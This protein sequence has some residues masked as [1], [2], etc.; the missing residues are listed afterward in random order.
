MKRFYKTAEVV[1]AEGGWTVVLDGRPVRTPARA[2]L[3]LPG[4]TLAERIA[5]EWNAQGERIDPAAMHHTG[6]ANAAIDRVGRDREDFVRNAVAFADTDTLLY[7]AEPGDPLAPRQEQLWEP[8]VRWAET[9]YDIVMARTAGI[10]PAAQPGEALDRL[11]AAVRARNDFELAGLLSMAGLLQSLLAALAAAEGAFDADTVWR[12]CQ[13]E[14]DYQAEQWG[15][16][17]E[18]AA[19]MKEKR[20]EF[21]AALGFC[22]VAKAP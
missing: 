9:R 2:A 18:A 19:R 22:M 21:D 5:D 17:A 8:I 6:L 3:L 20:R 10:M 15:E 14:V 11:A 12:A 4:R 16:D 13:L 7:R 1:S